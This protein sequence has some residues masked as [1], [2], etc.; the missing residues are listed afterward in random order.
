MVV[1]Q[2]ATT[3]EHLLRAAARQFVEGDVQHWWLPQTGRGVR[4]RVSDDRAWLCYCVAHYLEVTGDLAVLDESLPFLDGPVL[5]DQESDRFFQPTLARA[6]ASLFEHCALAL[7]QSLLIGAHGLPLIGSGDWNDAGLA[8]TL[9]A[10]LSARS[11]S[12]GECGAGYPTATCDLCGTDNVQARYTAGSP[13]ACTQ[14]G[15]HYGRFVHVEQQLSL[16]QAPD[17][18]TGGY[19]P[20]VAAV[21][22]TFPAQ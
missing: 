22:A 9:A 18:G 20:L 13:E 3:R 8:A 17:G 19:E 1:A 4:T 2:P 6:S 16:R 11:V 5:R 14:L 7:E 21:L 15:T 12:I 10:A